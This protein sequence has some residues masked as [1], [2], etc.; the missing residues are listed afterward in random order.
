MLNLSDNLYLESLGSG[1]SGLSSLSSLNL[2]GPNCL[3][4][5]NARHPLTPPPCQQPQQQSQQQVHSTSNA[6]NPTAAAG[7][8]HVL[9]HEQ[10]L[11]LLPELALLS[12]L[13]ELWLSHNR[14]M[15]VLPL[16]VC[17]LTALRLL[18][19]VDC[20]LRYLND[21]LWECRELRAL[22]LGDNVLADVPEEV[23]Q[24]QKLQVR[25]GVGGGVEELLARHSL[26]M[27]VCM[28]L[29]SNTIPVAPPHAVPPSC[30]ISLLMLQEL[31]LG[32]RTL[33]RLPQALLGLTALRRLVLWTMA[34]GQD[35]AEQLQLRSPNPVEIDFCEEPDFHGNPHWAYEA[36]GEEEYEAY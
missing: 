23:G 3:F 7:D 18:D 36:Q 9:S 16:A 17:R 10:Q 14:D 19:A 25:G 8:E 22:L 34:V 28:P 13:R 21:E 30:C 33:W 2:T 6:S 11:E 32:C 4:R 1:F 35:V 20:S 12:S 31:D 15:R 29:Y 27:L 26:T 24:L 5:D